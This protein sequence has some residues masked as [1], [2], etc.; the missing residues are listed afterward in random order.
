MT[1]AT[2]MFGLSFGFV[3][4]KA[5]QQLNVSGDKRW[6]VMPTSLLMAFFEVSVVIK[7]ASG[8]SLWAALPIG[9]GSGLG[10][11]AAMSLHRRLK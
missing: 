11:L 4:L 6:L 8:G 9:F 2:T 1:D 3:S 7:V 10:C 5:F